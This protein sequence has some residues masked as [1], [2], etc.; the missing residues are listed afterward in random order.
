MGNICSQASPI[1]SPQYILNKLGEC[2][3]KNLIKFKGWTLKLQWNSPMH[4]DRLRTD[5][6]VSGWKGS[7]DSGGKEIED[8]IKMHASLQCEVRMKK[9]KRN[10]IFIFTLHNSSKLVSVSHAE[11]L[12]DVQ[13][14][15]L[16]KN[17]L[18][19]LNFWRKPTQHK[20]RIWNLQSLTVCPRCREFDSI[21]TSS[22]RRFY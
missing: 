19:L 3:D 16:P 13:S 6:W 17:Y 7:K 9:R 8:G 10:N 2:A 4:Q 11:A 1:S 22:L 5:C 20:W 12:A 15:E 18:E 14:A 21:F